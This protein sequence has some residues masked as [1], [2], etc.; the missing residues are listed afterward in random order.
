MAWLDSGGKSKSSCWQVR[1][2]CRCCPAGSIIYRPLRTHPAGFSISY[3][4]S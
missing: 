3:E 2:R 1:E 4:G